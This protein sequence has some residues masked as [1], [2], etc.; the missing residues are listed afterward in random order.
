MIKEQEFKEIIEKSKRFSN[1]SM[2]YIGYDEV[3]E[4]SI[5]IN[6]DDMI[7]LC[8]YNKEAQSD[9]Y[10]FAANTSRNL[11]NALEDKKD[12]LITF[13]PKEW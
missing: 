2:Y 12:F 9:E 1:S 4:Y 13:I 5:L 3:K 6:N 10:Y 7:L 11:V 8:G